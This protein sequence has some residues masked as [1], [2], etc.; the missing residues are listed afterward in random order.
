MP[1]DTNQSCPL[2]M[3]HHAP[4][5]AWSSLTFGLPGRGV[6]IDHQTGSV[7]LAAEFLVALSRGPGRVQSLPF[8]SSYRELDLETKQM[9]ESRAA[10]G[11]ADG[12]PWEIIR[13]E[14]ITRRLTPCTDA[15]AAGDMTLTVYTPHPPLPDVDRGAD[16][17]AVKYACCPGILI[18]LAVD[19][20]KSKAPAYG[21]IGF[22]YLLR[23]SIRPL[24]WST[25]GSLCGV[26]CSNVWALAARS[27]EGTVCT[28]RDGN[29]APHV[30]A[31]EGII[32]N[33]GREG[34]I[35]LTAAP[36]AKAT[37]TAA[38]GFYHHGKATQG[39]DARYYYQKYFAAVEDVCGFVLEHADR[40][41]ADAKAFDR[42]AEERCPDE[43][44][45]QVFAQAVKSYYASSEFLEAG[46]RPYYNV[47][48]GQFFWRNT[49]DLAADH[50]AWELAH[51]SWVVRNITDLY[52]DRYTYRDEVRFGDRPGETFP[53]GL[54]FTHDMGSYTTYSPPGEG[55]YERSGVKGCYSFMTTEELLN[56]VYCVAAYALSTCDLDWADKR[57]EIARELLESMEHRDHHDPDVRN[58]L[59]EAESMKCGAD[60][61][62]ITSY[63]CLDHSLL[64]ARGNIY[65]AVKTWCAALMLATFFDLVKEKDAAA[66]ARRMA[67]KTAATLAGLFDAKGEY[68]PGNVLDRSTSKVIAA[69]EPLA[70]PLFCGLRT[71]LDSFEELKGLLRRHVATC[72]T[73]G[74]SLDSETGALRLSSAST[75]TWPSKSSLC[76]FVMEE[77]FGIDVAEQYP[78]VLRELRRWVQVGSADVTI[79]DQIL[80]DKG[81][82]RGAFYYP[83]IVTSSLWIDGGKLSS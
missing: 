58:G 29:V 42:E 26:A 12:A 21:F 8:C 24:D 38:F 74:N 80:S 14:A 45:R 11:D 46:G 30:E 76:I 63:D 62:E 19:N 66:R 27:E 57:R 51:N 73:P 41:R 44:K 52:I 70:V 59:L 83:R 47:S 75:N 67:A 54:C 10:D 79:S 56:G 2:F 22:S 13:P 60:G 72:M 82:A 17:E 68:F 9:E 31:G 65:I 18:E 5:G 50:L 71:E 61:C 36:G 25:D 15:Y 64:S 49:M 81:R 53:G 3:T 37:L 35:L 6:G 69:I 48:E 32:R 40:I 7:N 77:F 39:I 78:S 34:G 55:G 1:D 20:T 28:V 33:A 23:A 4:V 16:E 43:A